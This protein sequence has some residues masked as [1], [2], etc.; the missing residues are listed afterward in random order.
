[1]TAATAAARVFDDE[2]PDRHLGPAND[3]A[4]LA[5]PLETALTAG[6]YQPLLGVDTR[7]ALS[8]HVVIH[9][10]PMDARYVKGGLDHNHHGWGVGGLAGFQYYLNRRMAGPFVGLQGGDVE[11]FVGGRRGHNFGGTALFG[12]TLT[13][14]GGFVMSVGIGFGYWHRTG[15][16]DSG[17]VAL[18]EF[19]TLHLGLGWGE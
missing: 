13:Q 19:M 4:V 17:G 2:R 9:V 15:V 16:L 11:A 12:Y 18:P 7:F 3:F 6:F 1:M 10:R 5:F 8:D 14:N